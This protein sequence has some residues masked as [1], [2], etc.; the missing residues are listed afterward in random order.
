MLAMLHRHVET[1][2]KDFLAL[3]LDGEIDRIET[4]VIA[5][6]PDHAW[7]VHTDALHML[8]QLQ[9]LQPEIAMGIPIE[10]NLE[11]FEIGTTFVSLPPAAISAD[12]HVRPR[13]EFP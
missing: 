3:E 8:H 9:K 2:K 1:D 5:A 10:C 11:A 13:A 7:R 12:K 4:A 6:G